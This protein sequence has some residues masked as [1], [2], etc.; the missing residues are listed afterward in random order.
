MIK[1]QNVDAA[2]S[3]E[4]DLLRATITLAVKL[5]GLCT[6]PANVFEKPALCG[7]KSMVFKIQW[8]LSQVGL[9][10]LSVVKMTVCIK[11]ISKSPNTLVSASNYTLLKVPCCPVNMQK[12]FYDVF[13]LPD[14]ITKWLTRD[15]MLCGLSSLSTDHGEVY[16]YTPMDVFMYW[17]T[18]CAIKHISRVQFY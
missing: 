10:M 8:P 6:R 7:K 18:S 15:H 11:G 17:S 5:S 14:E 4:G 2:C 9:C 16:I 12:Y 3:I 13:S 1:W